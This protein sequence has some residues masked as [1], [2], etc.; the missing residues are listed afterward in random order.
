MEKIPYML[1]IGDKE[2]ET[3]SVSVRSRS[4][5]DLGQMPFEALLE[6]LLREIKEKVC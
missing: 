6:K 1:I 5:G 2:A 3:N 4:G